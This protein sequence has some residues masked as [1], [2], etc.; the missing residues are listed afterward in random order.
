MDLIRYIQEKKIL[1]SCYE[2]PMGHMDKILI[3]CDERYN[4][5]Q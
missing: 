1:Q 2:S 4:S 5:L 3:P